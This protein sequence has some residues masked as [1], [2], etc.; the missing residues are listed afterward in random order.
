MNITRLKEN[1][2]AD[3]HAANIYIT[4][5]TRYKGAADPAGLADQYFESVQARD[6]SSKLAFECF[7]REKTA[8]YCHL[9]AWRQCLA[10]MERHKSRG[11]MGTGGARM[12]QDIADAIETAYA[13]G[14]YQHRDGRYLFQV[15]RLRVWCEPRPGAVALVCAKYR[16][17]IGN[18]RSARY[19]TENA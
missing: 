17:G 1:V 12:L 18:S 19:G 4:L 3:D 2:F 15:G 9:D 7:I 16:R 5:R 11:V 6:A 10:D 14:D 13:T 8:R